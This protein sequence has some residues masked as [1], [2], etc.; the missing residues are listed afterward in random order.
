MRAFTLPRTMPVADPTQ[1]LIEVGGL[2]GSKHEPVARRVLLC[3]FAEIV[4]AG[5]PPGVGPPGMHA[6]TASAI[7]PTRTASRTR[8]RVT[9]AAVPAAATSGHPGEIDLAGRHGGGESGVDEQV[10]AI[11]V[12]RR[13]AAQEREDGRHLA[14]RHQPAVRLRRRSSR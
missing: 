7:A 6:L 11:H 12:G 8:I 9:L 2:G 1:L 4:D 10:H 5:V 13:V 3:T 14:G